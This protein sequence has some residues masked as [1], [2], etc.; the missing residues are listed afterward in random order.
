MIGFI[1]GNL[2]DVLEDK[3]VLDV[4]GVGY[5]IFIPSNVIDRLPDIGNEVLLHTYY[6]V[7]EDSA[8][9]F[10]FLTKKEKEV[11]CKLISVNGVGP[12]GAISILSSLSIEELV[13]A[14]AAADTKAFKKASGIG[15]KIAARICID[16]KDK[17]GIADTLIDD[18]ITTYNDKS[19]KQSDDVSVL[20]A[21]SYSYLEN[22]GFSSK[23]IMSTLAKMKIS[24]DMETEDI[25][26][27]ALDM[28]NK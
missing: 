19:I 27:I 24:S 3:V 6:Q 13:Y 28:M 25:V 21:E 1:R 22:L 17:L 9:L 16:L 8:A 20:K 23:E 10:G 4:S 11:F 12:K 26:A 14:I 7:K 2:F 18:E 5:E 15:P